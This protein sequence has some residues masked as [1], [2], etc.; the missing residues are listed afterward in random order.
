MLMMRKKKR[1]LES[2][3][4]NFYG[5]F[6]GKYIKTHLRYAPDNGIK[7]E[8]LKYALVNVLAKGHK[9]QNALNYA[10]ALTFTI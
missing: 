4:W 9:A 7:D 8:P 2:Y 5:H 1:A 6:S 10:Q 3:K